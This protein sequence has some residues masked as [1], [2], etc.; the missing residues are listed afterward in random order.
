MSNPTSNLIASLREQAGLVDRSYAAELMQQAAD[1]LY[2]SRNRQTEAASLKRDTSSNPVGAPDK[3][4]FMAGHLQYGIPVVHVE[5]ARGLW[6]EIERLRAERRPLL[7]FFSKH[8]I[9]S[10]LPP[11]C[12]VCGQPVVDAAIRHA[13]LAE[14]VVCFSCRDAKAER[15]TLRGKL[16]RTEGEL[17]RANS[18]YDQCGQFIEQQNGKI[19]LLRAICERILATAAVVDGHASGLVVPR[20]FLGELRQALGLASFSR[21][22]DETSG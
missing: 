11:S 7:E 9:G 1:A 17:E 5:Y 10:K 6:A 3:E 2:V 14:I 19:E 4:V 18:S 13:E 16:V 21:A 8:A 20:L 12:L 15:E 22:A